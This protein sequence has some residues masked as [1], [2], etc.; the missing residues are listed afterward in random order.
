VKEYEEMLKNNCKDTRNN[1]YY[2]DQVKPLYNDNIISHL[3]H[4]YVTTYITCPRNLA[5]EI[6]SR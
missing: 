4:N 3:M 6:S 1:V 2:L 5:L